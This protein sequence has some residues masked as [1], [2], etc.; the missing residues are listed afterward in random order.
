MK[1]R[2][3]TPELYNGLSFTETKDQKNV[4]VLDDDDV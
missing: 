4:D 1:R 2:L 3:K